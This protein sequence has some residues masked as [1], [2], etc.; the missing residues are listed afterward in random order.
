MHIWN[1]YDNMT[2]SSNSQVVGSTERASSQQLQMWFFEHF[3][4]QNCCVVCH[5]YCSATVEQIWRKKLSGKPHSI[6]LLRWF[7]CS[8]SGGRKNNRKTGRKTFEGVSVGPTKWQMTWTDFK[9]ITYLI[10]WK[11][12]YRCC[13][14][15]V[16]LT[17]AGQYL[18]KLAHVLQSSIMIGA[19]FFQHELSFCFDES[20]TNNLI[21]CY[22]AGST[23]QDHLSSLE[24]GFLNIFSCQNLLRGLHCH[25]YCFC[26]RTTNMARK[27][28]QKT[29]FDLT[30]TLA[31][32][33]TGKQLKNLWR[34][35]RGTNKLE[36]CKWAHR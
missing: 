24:P 29:T 25:S 2:S 4:H 5:A 10:C 22:V 36:N 1:I 17:N 30:S 18:I 13:H 35:F 15:E 27:N 6:R 23:D 26:Y 7:N 33:K 20:R 8:Q 16:G 34:S 19:V 28:V 21:R 32:Q 11:C 9:I 31:N 14:F 3:S 12:T